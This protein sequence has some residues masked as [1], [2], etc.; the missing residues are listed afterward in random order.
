MTR[1]VIEA[2]RA[3]YLG[4]A[5][6][7][8]E[9]RIAAATVAVGFERPFRR[10]LGSQ[11]LRPRRAA[12]IPP[13]THHH[14]VAEGAMGFVYLDGLADDVAALRERDLEEHADAVIAALRDPTEG[15]L[16]RALGQLGVVPRPAPPAHVARTV[17]ALEQD[18]GRFPRVEAAA[19][20]AGLSASRFQ[21]VFR[22]ATGMPFRRYRLWRRMALAVATIARG[23]TLTEAAHDA[24]FAGSAH[25]SAAFRDMFGLP[26]SAL[27]RLDPR[28]ELV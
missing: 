2:G 12:L 17:R 22:A 25:F 19:A 13:G 27:V 24:G 18:P 16:P 20:H 26:P 9:H 4:P 21:H 15:P 3:L 5:L 28:I 14:L 1:I 6:D 11:S 7:L 8:A 23:R 10:A